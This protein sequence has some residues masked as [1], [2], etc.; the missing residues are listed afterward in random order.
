MNF[1]P[2]L[3][4]ISHRAPFVALYDIQGFEQALSESI[5]HPS[6][7]D[8]ESN[9]S[10]AR[11]SS[12]ETR[13]S[14]SGLTRISNVQAMGS[15]STTSDLSQPSENSR[16]Y[17]D[18]SEE[19]DTTE[20]SSHSLSSGSSVPM[21]GGSYDSKTRLRLV[22]ETG[23]TL[24]DR[25]HG[26]PDRQIDAV[27]RTQKIGRQL[28]TNGAKDAYLLGEALIGSTPSVALLCAGSMDQLEVLIMSS[29]YHRLAWET[30]DPLIGFT[31]DST[32]MIISIVFGWIDPDSTKDGCLVRI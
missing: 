20:R 16:R 5:E 3:S 18:D 30:T 19:S 6:E 8:T 4:A 23:P 2:G 13:N 21:K 14:E 27:R 31:W 11:K 17:D 10:A 22:A 9:I 32:G 1:F 12:K 28:V 15:D 7:S 29:L 26:I 24:E 25:S